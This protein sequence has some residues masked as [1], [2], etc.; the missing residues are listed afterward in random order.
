MFGGQVSC[1]M[2][3][4]G[5]AKQEENRKRHIIFVVVVRKDINLIGANEHQMKKN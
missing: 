3:V 2:D 1:K 5:G 4:G